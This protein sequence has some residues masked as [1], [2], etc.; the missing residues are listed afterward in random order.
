MGALREQIRREITENPMFLQEFGE[1]SPVY[2]AMVEGV[3][4]FWEK[5][6]FE[7]IDQRMKSEVAM[8]K[9]NIAELEKRREENQA[10]NEA[11][12]NRLK[13]FKTSFG[14]FGIAVDSAVLLAPIFLG[15][16]FMIASAKLA[17]SIKLRESFQRF[18]LRN[19][20][21]KIAITDAEFA[22]AV[23]LWLDPLAP[24]RKRK[25]RLY[26]LFLPLVVFA[27]TL[28]IVLYCWTLPEAFPDLTR[29]DYVQ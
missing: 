23:P 4:Q 12:N 22:L 19:D 16:M 1:T 2:Q 3:N 20:P 6:H 17:E 14:Q 9:D 26:V 7:E 28:A 8:L 21:R 10:R 5:H 18:F 29:F 15:V 24:E 27:V 25:L 13:H 11:L